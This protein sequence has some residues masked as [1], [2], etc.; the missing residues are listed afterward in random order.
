MSY[1]KR[2]GSI[3]KVEAGRFVDLEDLLATGQISTHE[4]WKELEKEYKAKYHYVN[5]IEDV[6]RSV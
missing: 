5:W 1:Q 6:P 3:S 4:Y 2:K